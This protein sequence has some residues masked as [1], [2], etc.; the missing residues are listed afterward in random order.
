MTHTPH[1]NLLSLYSTSYYIGHIQEDKVI[2]LTD[3][4]GG[5][6]LGLVQATLLNGIA[7]LKKR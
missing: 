2:Q 7:Y 3:S 5:W 4:R 1:S 6:C